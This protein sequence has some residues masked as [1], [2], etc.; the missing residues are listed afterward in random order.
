MSCMEVIVLSEEVEVFHRSCNIH[1]TG[2]HIQCNKV[3]V[4]DRETKIQVERKG[5]LMDARRPLETGIQ[6]R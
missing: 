2:Q 5:S 3:E 6:V 1:T 4:V